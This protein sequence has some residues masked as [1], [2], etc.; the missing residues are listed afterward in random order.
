MTKAIHS[1]LLKEYPGRTKQIEELQRLITLECSVPFLY[2]NGL[3]ST[4]KTSI[5][6]RFFELYSHEFNSPSKKNQPTKAPGSSF[7]F[8]FIDCIDCLSQKT[9]F[10]RILRSWFKDTKA[11]SFKSIENTCETVEDFILVNNSIPELEFDTKYIVLDNAE[12]LKSLDPL[13][14]P[15]LLEIS[16]ILQ[17]SIIMISVLPWE[18]I[19]PQATSCPE[20]ICLYFTQ[21]SK[22]EVI[23][24]LKLDCPIDEPENFFLTF[25]DSLYETF[26]RSCKDLN[27]FRLLVSLLYPKYVQPVFEGQATRNE[28]A[29]LFKLCQPYFVLAIDKLHLREI[30]AYD[31]QSKSILASAKN[32]F[33]TIEKSINKISSK[34]GTHH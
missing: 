7:R 14:I 19:R 13:F 21:Y 2:I 8:A 15:S 31:W 9:L 3:P 32:D 30:S 16:D 12:K 20:P 6:N 34:S 26:R 17:I 10:R 23:D 27:E 25:V 1:Q 28:T 24:I 5:V 29:R 11:S 18:N 4:G 33:E 22:P